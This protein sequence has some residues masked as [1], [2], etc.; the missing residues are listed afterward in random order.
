M[1]VWAE[2]LLQGPLGNPGEDAIYGS[3]QARP[4]SSVR[5]FSC[6][7]QEDSADGGLGGPKE[8]RPITIADRQPCVASAREVTE[9]RATPSLKS[10]W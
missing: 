5:F 10:S 1:V 9:A 2:M 3:L 6:C 8:H 4:T 7:W